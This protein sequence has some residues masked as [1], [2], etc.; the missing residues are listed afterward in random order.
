MSILHF[1]RSRI[2][3]QEFAAA[4]LR[5]LVSLLVQAMFSPHFATLSDLDF[6][7]SGNFPLC[8]S[9]VHIIPLLSSYDV[10]LEA[11]DPNSSN[12]NDLM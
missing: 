8:A 6:V 12:Q 4:R 1:L 9:L 10:C 11:F 5:P 2:N 3:L 7:G